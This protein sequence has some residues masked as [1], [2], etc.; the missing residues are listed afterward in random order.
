MAFGS[1]VIVGT[2]LSD[3]SFPA[4]RHA[5]AWAAEHQRPLLVAHVLSA[6]SFHRPDAA[7][8]E[9]ALEKLVS[10][11]VSI[12]AELSVLHGAA[13]ASLIQLASERKASLLA[14]GAS[15]AGAFK[16]AFFGSTAASVARYAD[17]SVLVAR[18]DPKAGPI[19]VGTDFSDAVTP[20]LVLGGTEAKQRGAKLV[21]IH[22]MYEPSSPLNLLGP[23]V[24]SAP[25]PSEEARKAQH[26]AA[27]T[28]LES[29]LAAHGGEGE[30]VVLE[31]EPGQALTSYAEK[32]GAALVV[33]GTHG[34][35]GFARMALG[36]VAE[37]VVR[38]APCS[39]LVA[40]AHA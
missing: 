16:Q 7:E 39:V 40:R 33:V 12:D 27:V 31:D 6:T 25:Q 32:V 21:L 35:T 2:D 14:V 17:C 28:T 15:G 8:V 34:R 4:I 10:S 30:C 37:I 5:A 23:I 26:Q 19:V 18:H 9:R 38:E 22:S 20:A 11:L 1:P 13:H 29:L 24:V 36:S 3:A